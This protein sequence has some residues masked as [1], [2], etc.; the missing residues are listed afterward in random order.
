VRAGPPARPRAGARDTRAPESEVHRD[1]DAERARIRDGVWYCVKVFL[2][3]RLGLFVLAV[4]ATALLP[5]HVAF[6]HSLPAAVSVP[7]WPAHEIT[8]GAHNLF[9]AWERFD[10][11][12]F[13]RIATAG[14]AGGDGS[15]AFFP[16]Y[17]LAI[18]GVSFVI[19][20]HPLAAALVVSNAA[21]LGALIVLFFLTSSE[22]SPG[23][24]RKTVLYISIFPTAFFFL[25]PYSE[26]LFLLVSVGSFWAARRRR[27][28][29]AGALGALAAATRVFGILL[30]A[31]LALEALQQWRAAR[32]ARERRALGGGDG[33]RNEA[34]TAR[35]QREAATRT[36]LERLGWAGGTSL[37][38]VAYLAYWQVA[39]GHFWTPLKIQDNWQRVAMAPWT[40]LI[41]GTK[42]AFGYLGNYPLGYHQLDWLVAVPAIALAVYAFVRFRPAYGLYTGASLLIPLSFVFPLRPLMSFPRLVLPLFP[43]FWALARL[44]E[45]R[46]LAHDVVVA[47]SA[48]GLGVMTILFVDWLYVF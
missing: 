7:G 48:A 18:R 10:A 44:T 22:L 42:D 26:S 38:L 35:L 46:R 37:G 39:F 13:L 8:P 40:T 9:T 14:Y 33:P 4:V 16:L 20:G 47:V 5:S 29:L 12:W 11:L 3:M 2:A 23:A 28:P 17:P 6:P 19:G 27:W 34:E 21:F 45:R 30:G 31:A 1:R 24:A 25:A 43:L 36:L 15:A 32:L 41:D